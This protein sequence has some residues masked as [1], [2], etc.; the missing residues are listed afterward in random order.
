MIDGRPAGSGKATF[1]AAG[2]T[3]ET[4]RDIIQTTLLG[5]ITHQGGR[6]LTT[7]TGVIPGHAL[8][9][10]TWKQGVAEPSADQHS[11][12]AEHQHRCQSPPIGDTPSGDDGNNGVD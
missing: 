6:K 2:K 4:T 8:G 12:T 10:T 3:N 7:G 1:R 11:V 5:E 9:G